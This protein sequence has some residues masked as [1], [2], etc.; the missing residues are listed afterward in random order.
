MQ[1]TQTA[2]LT[3]EDMSSEQSS[4]EYLESHAMPS[5]WTRATILVRCNANIRGHSA[6]TL[7]VVDTMIKLIQNDIV[8]VVPLRGSVSASGDL[9]PLAYIAGAIQGNPDVF[10][11]VGS[12]SGAAKVITAQQA[13]QEASI[14]PIVLGPKEGLSLI[15]GTAAAAAVASLGLYEANQLAVLAQLLTALSSEAMNANNEWAHPFIAAVRP[16]VGQ[17]EASQNMRTFLRG[18]KLSYGLEVTKDRFS[19]GLAQERYALRSSPQWLS[20]YLEDL[21]LAERQLHTELNSTSDNPVVNVSDN[22]IHCGANFQAAAV[23]SA[24]EKT[25]LALQAIGK[26][27]FSQASEIINHDLSNGLPPNLAADDPSSS[28]CLKGLDVNMAAY[29]SELGFLANPVS[30]HV[31]S[32]EMHNQAINSLALLSA[33]QTLAAVECLS[34]LVASHLYTCCQGVDL[35]TLN[36]TFIS[37]LEV[38]ARRLIA[39][40]INAG[41][42]SWELFETFWPLFRDAWYDHVDLDAVDRCDKASETLAVAAMAH[43]DLVGKLGVD[44]LSSHCKVLSAFVLESYH[45]HRDDFFKK[46]TTAEYLGQGSRMAYL[47]VREHLGVPMHR[48]LVEHP[49]AGAP[50]GNMIDGRL[51]KT[52][53]SWVSMIYESVRD[54]SLYDQMFKFLQAAD[55]T[56]GVSGVNGVNGSNSIGG[57]ING[58]MEFFDVDSS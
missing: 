50:D 45:A 41:Q 9:M 32:A 20:P 52:I 8:P 12:K 2:V 13:L 35:R 19:A 40:L 25:R 39:G 10:V 11:R 56:T 24:T 37:R 5:A 18:S 22:D 29:T 57:V 28:F 17:I 16:H 23:T 54:G 4:R 43:T 58:R 7:P 31:Q 34:L 21:V 3:R 26:M 27:L 49:V 47:F 38:S 42:A 36:M 51:K 44:K 48:G 14:E 1:L 33:R 6:M 55:A 15:N 46:P 53:G 30:N